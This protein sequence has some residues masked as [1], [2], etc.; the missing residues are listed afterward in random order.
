M[1]RYR[2][3]AKKTISDTYMHISS[4]MRVSA[5]VLMLARYAADAAASV[6][7]GASPAKIHNGSSIAKNTTPA[8]PNHPVACGTRKS[9]KLRLRTQSDV[10][11]DDPI[12]RAMLRVPHVGVN[13]LR[14]PSRGIEVSPVPS[15]GK[16]YATICPNA[17]DEA[18]IAE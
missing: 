17:P 7:C 4:R 12:I 3:P 14:C 1:I 5:M 11:G 16:S 2:N 6:I 9:L 13:P 8:T 15:S 18:G 10:S